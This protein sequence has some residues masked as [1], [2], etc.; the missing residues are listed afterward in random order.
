VDSGLR[1]VVRASLRGIAGGG[2]DGRSVAKY[3]RKEKQEEEVFGMGCTS[4]KTG[5]RHAVAERTE[6][7]E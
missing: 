5:S 3:S 6:I 7:I 4:C 1:G 2:S